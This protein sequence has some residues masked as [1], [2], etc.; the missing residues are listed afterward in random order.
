MTQKQNKVMTY[1]PFIAIL[2]MVRQGQAEEENTR[3]AWMTQEEMIQEEL[4]M[5]FNSDKFNH[6]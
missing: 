2:Q 3:R 6:I 1:N 5:A 4:M